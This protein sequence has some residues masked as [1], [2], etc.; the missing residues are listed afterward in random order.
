MNP[1]IN[2]KG[3]LFLFG[4]GIIL[5]SFLLLQ[6]FFLTEIV[7]LVLCIRRGDR[8]PLI[9]EFFSMQRK[10]YIFMPTG[11]KERAQ[12]MQVKKGSGDSPPDLR[13]PWIK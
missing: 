10:D 2:V 5:S 12:K 7:L 13:K 3:A 4:R 8:A 6:I 9:A 11:T 1:Q